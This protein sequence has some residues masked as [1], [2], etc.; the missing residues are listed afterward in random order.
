MDPGFSSFQRR[1]I[2]HG[3]APATGWRPCL[4]ALGGASQ[5]RRRWLFPLQDP[6]RGGGAA[7]AEKDLPPSA[8]K[9]GP[10]KAAAQPPATSPL[11]PALHAGVCSGFFLDP[12]SV[13]WVFPVS[14]LHSTFANL[15]VCEKLYLSSK[16]TKGHSWEDFTSDAAFTHAVQESRAVLHSWTEAPCRLDTSASFFRNFYSIANK[17]CSLSL[18]V[19]CLFIYF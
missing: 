13:R 19:K 7:P 1:R 5:P 15:L 17:H 6:P 10:L 18:S 3:T 16:Q 14:V 8:L 9:A 12:H 11:P 4:L 2:G